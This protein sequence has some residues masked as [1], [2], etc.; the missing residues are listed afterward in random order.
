MRLFGFIA[1]S[2]GNVA[3]TFA[4]VAPVLLAAAG[5]AVDFQALRLQRTALQE[6]ADALA[7]RGAREFL[8]DNA[9]ETQIEALVRATA[10][11]QYADALGAF[12]LAADAEA[13]DK[14]VTATLTQQPRRGIFLHHLG[15]FQAPI[16]ASATAVARGS[17]NVCVIALEDKDAGAV[18]AESNA[19]LIATRCSILSNSTSSHG[20]AASGFSKLKAALICSAGGAQGGSSNFEPR[21]LTDC[22]AYE[23]PLKDRLEPDVGA[24][25]HTNL[26]LGDASP[27]I[28]LV[29]HTLTTAISLL[30]G[31]DEDTLIGY[32]RYDLTPGV[33]CGGV[34]IRADADVHLAP[35]VYVIKDGDLEIEL[36]GRLFGKEVGLFFTGAGAVFNFK[37]QS[38]VHLTAPADG[39]MAGML[40]MEDRARASTETYAILSSNARTLLGTIY[41]PKGNLLI[42]S[43]MPIADESA[44]TAIVTRFLRMSGSPQLVLNTDYA[45]T[46]VPVPEGLGPSGGQVFLRE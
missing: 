21:A 28:G 4:L 17:T 29:G 11:A 33:Y 9:T 1:A 43:L 34:R 40:M 30:D 27:A 37:P 7:T 35:G 41:L 19:K 36:G 13:D 10:D 20:V 8:L 25:D 15:A 24:C 18:K 45:L 32:T 16:A 46:D 26:D 22:P 14:S 6:A 31:S 5:G 39:I 44:Y 3:L 23:D 42:D 2:C 12:T 38:I